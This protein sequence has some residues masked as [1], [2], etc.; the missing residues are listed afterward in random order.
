MNIRVV[1]IQAR[2]ALWKSRGAESIAAPIPKY[3]KIGCSTRDPGGYI[4]EVGQSTTLTYG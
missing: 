1:N 4:I 2:Y 3:G